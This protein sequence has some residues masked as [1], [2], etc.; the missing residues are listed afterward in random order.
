MIQAICQRL[1]DMDARGL[2]GRPGSGVVVGIDRDP[3]AKVTLLLFDDRGELTAVAK[4]ARNPGVEPAL[5][6]E[7]TALCRLAAEALPSLRPQVPRPLLLERIAGRLVLASTAVAGAPLTVRYYTP[8]HVTN[9][10]SVAADFAMAG[11]W[12][13]ALQCET[14]TATATLGEAYQ[15]YVV[16]IVER[17]R[18]LI[19]G[20]CWELQLFAAIED[21][22]RALADL[23]VPTPLLHGDYAIGNILVQAGAVA[24][25]V[26][27]ELCREASLPLLDVL[28]FAASYSSF[29]DRAQ[30]P[31]A[32]R[33]RGHP[34]WRAASQQ[35][36]APAGWMNLTG[37][38]YGFFGKGWY[39][40]LVRGFVAE[41]A[42][43]LGLPPSVLP[44]LIRAF[45]LD[46]ATV[47]DNATYASGYRA[48]LHAVHDTLTDRAVGSVG[49][50]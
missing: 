1:N 17:Y 12:I 39:P 7:G 30:P 31:R 2:R 18:R 35:W 10:D 5:R 48:L 11:R 40:D 47:L 20:S 3:M 49:A 19:G 45:L 27:W 9:A 4:V 26:D 32:D 43:R 24:G 15:R 37:F 13:T 21:D 14:P 44:L 8:G 23:E 46:Q 28:K 16:P 36:P 6:R 41:H 34:G 29:L 50:L 42:T 25:V 38:M 33:L 22:A